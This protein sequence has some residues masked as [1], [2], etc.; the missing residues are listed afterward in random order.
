MYG[1]RKHAFCYSIVLPE[2]D[3]QKVCGWCWPLITHLHS[4][5]LFVKEIELNDF[6]LVFANVCNE[7]I[8][9][10]K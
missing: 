7:N 10:I 5:I 8:K 6:V 2:E 9:L 1:M 3:V 4:V